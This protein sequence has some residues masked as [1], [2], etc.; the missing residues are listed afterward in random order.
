MHRRRRK[1]PAPAALS[2]LAAAALSAAAASPATAAEW[3]YSASGTWWDSAMWSDAAVPKFPDDEALFFDTIES[4][5][6]V[7]VNGPASIGTLYISNTSPI[8]F[9]GAGPL[10][11]ASNVADAFVGVEAGSHA[12]S[13]SLILASHAVIHVLEPSVLTISGPLDTAPRVEFAKV[14]SGELRVTG[15]QSYG[16]G[17]LFIAIEGTTSFSTDAAGDAAAAPNLSMNVENTAHVRFAA[18]QHLTSLHVGGAFQGEDVAPLVIVEPHGGRVLHTRELAVDPT[19]T[20]DLTDNALVVQA[21]TAQDA[22]AV[23]A[24]V[25][26]A[27][28]SARNATAGTWLGRGITSTTAA[29]NPLT[30]LAA[31]LNPGLATFSGGVIDENAIIVTHTYNGDANLDATINADDYFRIDQGF[32]A[33]PQ[34]PIYRDGDF[35]YDD[36]INADDYFLID[37]AF[38][39]QGPPL[40]GSGSQGPLTSL[41]VP[42]PTTSLLTLAATTLLARRRP[43]H[44]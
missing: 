17:S 16:L 26:T 12:V 44:R 21:P 28:A 37:Q 11:L 42:E 34:N 43:R 4:P 38:L 23:L 25:D 15:P 22:A 3:I 18:S 7:S 41:S 32:L 2:L 9:G 31:V 30:T 40:T 35:N 33:Q 13:A 27:I 39:G 29:A 5:A 20:L 10:T 1:T 14:S 19:G 8:T 36:R 6:T 24:H